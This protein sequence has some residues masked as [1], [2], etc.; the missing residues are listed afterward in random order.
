MSEDWSESDRNQF[1][2]LIGEVINTKRIRPYQL[3]LILRSIL[4]GI[5]QL[6]DKSRSVFVSSRVYYFDKQRR[7]RKANRTSDKEV[8]SKNRT[9]D[10]KDDVDEPPISEINFGEIKKIGEDRV[11]I[12]SDN[13]EKHRLPV[14]GKMKA[15]VSKGSGGKSVNPVKKEAKEVDKEGS[16]NPKVPDQKDSRRKIHFSI[17]VDNDSIGIEP[18]DLIFEFNKQKR[19]VIMAQE[20]IIINNEVDESIVNRINTLANKVTDPIIRSNMQSMETLMVRRISDNKEMIREL[21]RCL[22]GN[23]DHVIEDQKQYIKK[24]YKFNKDFELTESM[25]DELNMI[26]D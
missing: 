19:Q 21:K 11:L 4:Y 16:N 14:D 13:L 22:K 7:K 6:E 24:E 5:D 2:F 3:I 17:K 15:G 12:T 9:R 10:N 25:M 23:M 1:E 20:S 8:G 26:D 18:E